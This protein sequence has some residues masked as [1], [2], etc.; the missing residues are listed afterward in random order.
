MGSEMCIRDSPKDGT[1]LV[2]CTFCL[3]F[4]T[5]QNTPIYYCGKIDTAIEDNNGVWSFDHKT[6]FQFGE[7]F[8]AMMQM[9]GGQLGYCWALGQVLKRPVTGYIIDAVRIR[10]PTRAS[11]RSV[12]FG[13]VESPVDASDFARLPFPIPYA[14]TL[15]DWRSDTLALIADILWHHDR[16]YFPRHRWNCTNKFGKCDFFEVCSAPREQRE[17]ILYHSTLYEESTWS[18][19]KQKTKEKQ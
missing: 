14:S 8:T 12:E 5:V 3:P 9:D 1:P 16:G 15:E 2:E 19:L 10:R 6:A 17:A 13:G 4:G 7:T 11:S 18:P